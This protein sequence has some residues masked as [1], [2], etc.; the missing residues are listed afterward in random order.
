MDYRVLRPDICFLVILVQMV[1]SGTSL[2]HL[3]AS[4]LLCLAVTV[5]YFTG[6]TILISLPTGTKIFNWLSTYLGNLL[7]AHRPVSLLLIPYVIGIYYI[8]IIF[9]NF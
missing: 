3:A 6:I 4:C 8:I 2:S 5:S 1:P 7:S 9:H